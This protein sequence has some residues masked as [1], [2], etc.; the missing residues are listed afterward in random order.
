MSSLD[1]SETIDS[2]ED[3]DRIVAA[4]ETNSGLP[5][6]GQGQNHSSKNIKMMESDTSVASVKMMGRVMKSV[7]ELYDSSDSED[8]AIMQSLQEKVSEC[9]GTKM[10]NGTVA[11][12]EDE[13]LDE[14]LD[15]LK[16]DKIS[17]SISVH[18]S[19]S[20]MKHS[21]SEAVLGLKH[22]ANRTGSFESEANISSRRLSDTESKYKSSRFNPFDRDLQID[23]D[24]FND[25]TSGIKPK[26]P[27]GRLKSGNFL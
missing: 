20:K 19:S 1:L 13:Q 24:Y 23:E 22:S 7:A 6:K 3:E 16:D 18:T 5:Q 17:A 25:S 8:E 9:N 11:V 2:S 26:T 27:V 15:P 4:M 21:K 14:D 12:Q 10:V